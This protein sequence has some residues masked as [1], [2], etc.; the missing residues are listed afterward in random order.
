MKTA[1]LALGALLAISLAACHRVSKDHA[2]ILKLDPPIPKAG[3]WITM[4]VK[5]QRPVQL[6]W[7]SGTV[8]IFMAP[9]VAL[10]PNE[11]RD[12][13]TFRMMIPGLVLIPKGQYEAAAWGEDQDGARW[14]GN[15]QVSVP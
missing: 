3:Q 6:Q 7:V 2:L 13:W 14:Q 4:T 11:S 10:K 12:T 9:V 1:W 8:K 5:P 15:Y